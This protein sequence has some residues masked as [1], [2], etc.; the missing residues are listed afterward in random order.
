[1]GRLNDKVAV[2]TG[3]HG[4][5]GST[6]AKLFAAEGA[7]VVCADLDVKKLDALVRDINSHGGR[8]AAVV[9]DVTR[10]ADVERLMGFAVSRFGAINVLHN[11][12]TAL[13]PDD[14]TVLDTPNEAWDLSLKVN[15]YAAIWG[16]KH[17][18]P[19]MIEAGGGSIINMAS[20]SYCLGDIERVAYS[21]SKAAVASLTKQ[22]ATTHGRFGI[23]VN[24]I[25]PGNSMGPVLAA[26]F[27]EFARLHADYVL[28]RR[29]GNADDQA[30][31]ALFLASDESA[32]MTGQVLNN[33]GGLSAYM[34][35][36]PALRALGD[37]GRQHR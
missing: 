27:P 24:A 35:T 15:V 16:C 11:N 20:M 2:V 9:T 37:A 33:D 10:E 29:L 5:I 26:K 6:V 21:V 28:T 17:A 14:R 7:A 12:A 36:I 8:A 30:Y 23:R 1:M 34:P 19:R 32:F 22:V 31:L 13:S 4:Y 3:A 25:S 18:I